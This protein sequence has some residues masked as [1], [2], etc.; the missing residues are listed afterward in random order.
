[1]RADVVDFCF[2]SLIS[3]ICFGAISA[4]YICS[5][6]ANYH[7]RVRVVP[8][9]SEI[10]AQ[11]VINE[12]ESYAKSHDGWMSSRQQTYGRPWYLLSS[13]LMHTEL[14]IAVIPALAEF[15]HQ[16][17]PNKLLPVLSA[18]YDIPS[19][20]LS[21]GD[22]FIVKY[23]DTGQRGLAVHKVRCL[24]CYCADTTFMRMQEVSCRVTSP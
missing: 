17:L 20:A 4:L 6:E 2:G 12:A 23:T 18:A 24:S 9:L 3:I 21:F 19:E 10:E 15:R 22:V 13:P 16:S 1:M 7:T 8:M 11:M 5:L 14:P